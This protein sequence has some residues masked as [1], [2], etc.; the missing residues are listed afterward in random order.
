MLKKVSDLITYLSNE[1]QLRHPVKQNGVVILN[2]DEICT[3]ETR[4][5]M[6]HQNLVSAT[7]N[8]HKEA[9]TTVI[10]SMTKGITGCAE[11]VMLFLD[12]LKNIDSDRFKLASMNTIMLVI[13]CGFTITAAYTNNGATNVKIIR[14][15]CSTRTANKHNKGK[16]L[17]L[18][19]T[20]CV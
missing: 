15:F 16:K 12:P 1:K 7:A 2:I 10:L 8:S 13:D 5:F 17:S 6:G 3:T 18:N 9:A 4:M 19:V 20:K 11:T 14:N